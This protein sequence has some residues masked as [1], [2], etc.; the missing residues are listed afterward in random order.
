LLS[1]ET[2]NTLFPD[3]A[4]AK[5]SSSEALGVMLVGLGR[6]YIAR[7]VN[8]L[9]QLGLLNLPLPFFASDLLKRF[10]NCL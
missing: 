6:T 9:G 8:F 1:S 2:V 4:W 5:T 7:L 10:G 3:P